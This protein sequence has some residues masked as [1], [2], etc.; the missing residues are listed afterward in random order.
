ME[1]KHFI[2]EALLSITGGVEEA[3]K[4]AGRFKILGVK[5]ESGL[6]GNYADFDVSV[7]VNEQ[8]KIDVSGEVKASWLSVVS[9]KV[10]SKIGQ[11]ST[12]KNTHRLTFKV[13][14]TDK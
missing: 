2:K 10:G 1:L 13:Y 12:N 5:H 7:V 8:S 9:A 11:S 14:I 4:E 3:N 6:E